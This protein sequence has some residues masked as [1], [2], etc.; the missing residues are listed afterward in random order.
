MK[1]SLK[2]YLITCLA[3]L[4]SILGFAP[5]HL[6]GALIVGIAVLFYISN[7]YTKN[8]SFFIGFFYGLGYFGA[9]VSWVYVSIHDY[10]H[11]HP[12]LAAFI[13]FIFILY[14]S[15]F[16][17]V[18]LWAYRANNANLN[19]I[20][21][22]LLFTV[23]WVLFEYARSHFL[24]GFPWLLVGYSS[25]DLP[26]HFLLPIIG[27][28]G[29]S[30]I[31]V[32]TAAL[33]TS[34]VQ[35]KSI[36]RLPYTITFL[37][38]FT[39]PFLFQQPIVKLD[40]I[41]PL[42]VSIIQQNLS[43]RDKWDESLFNHILKLYDAEINKVIKHSNLVVLP[44]SAIP[45]PSHYVNDL[46]N[47]WNYLAEANN[48]ALLLGIP[49][50]KDNQ[51]YNGMIALGDA[52][53]EYKKRHLVLFGEWIPKPFEALM[54]WL[55]IPLISMASGNS[56]QSL[57]D[58]KGFSIASLICYELA[59]PELLRSQLPAANLIVS[60]SDD[61]WFG[62]SLAMYQQLQIAQV[63]SA[64]AN[65]YQVVANNDGLSSIIDSQGNIIN[66][67]KPFTAETLTE[68]AFAISGTTPWVNLGDAPLLFLAIS[69]LMTAILRR[70]W[71]R[72]NRQFDTAVT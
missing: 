12:L 21:N 62:H 55:N 40:N 33:L 41:P 37:G 27:T 19:I 69:I 50:A 38:L 63:L 8:S 66:K 36:K 7:I 46:L 45:A 60:M 58:I 4:F 67:L 14:L 3:G 70:L 68:E 56:T 2:T 16:F 30:A 57:I 32:F 20:Q 42:K 48:A 18:M 23:F 35:E 44:E 64:L 52:Y 34:I 39:V 6:P 54:H 10:G 43:M 29:V 17:A 47:S 31:I 28:Y 65:R 5:F 51:I 1:P 61:G 25:M 49:L 11:L 22:S 24:T 53:G 72:K 9:G 26:F 59:Y 13:T 71:Y 15:L